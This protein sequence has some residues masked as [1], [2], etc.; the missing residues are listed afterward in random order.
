[1]TCYL[2]IFFRKCRHKQSGKEYAVKIMSRRV[3]CSREVQLL[4]LCQGHPHIVKLHEAFQD[5]V[6]AY[7]RSSKIEY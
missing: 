2:L 5:E 6:I 3:D 1:M 7:Y 4:R